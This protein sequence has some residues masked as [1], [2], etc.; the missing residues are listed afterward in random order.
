MSEFNSKHLYRLYKGFINYSFK[1]NI[2]NISNIL[3]YKKEV[4]N[5][6]C[7]II[8]MNIPF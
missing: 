1:F 6:F 5:Y 2:T 7:Q 8:N 4:F 3:E